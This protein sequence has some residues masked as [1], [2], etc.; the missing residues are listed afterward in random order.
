MIIIIATVSVIYLWFYLLEFFL[1]I[2]DASECQ[3]YVSC[4]QKYTYI[5]ETDFMYAGDSN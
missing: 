4:Y 1:I 5:I 2:I 3:N